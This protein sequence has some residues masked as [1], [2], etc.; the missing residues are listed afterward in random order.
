MALRLIQDRLR[1]QWHIVD[2]ES[3]TGS[4]YM[5]GANGPPVLVWIKTM[6]GHP[7]APEKNEMFLTAES[8]MR[9]PGVCESCKSN[10]ALLRAQPPAIVSDSGVTV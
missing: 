6:C 1:D 3:Q 9:H 4:Q 10:T 2:P 8:A 5:V 7:G